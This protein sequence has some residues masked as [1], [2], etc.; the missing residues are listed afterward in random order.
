MAGIMIEPIA[1]VSA[2]A[3]PDTPEKMAAETTETWA[4]PPRRW[5]TSA[6]ANSTIRTVSPPA[7]IRLPARM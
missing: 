6:L 3:E 5:P 7:L 1:A 2:V 4:S